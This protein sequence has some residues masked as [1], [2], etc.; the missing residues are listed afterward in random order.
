MKKVQVTFSDEQLEVIEGLKGLL[1]ESNAEVVRTIVLFWLAENSYISEAT[2][3][4][5]IGKVD[6]NV[7]TTE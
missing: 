6:S 1:G 4:R 7:N 5:Q 3:S 2:K